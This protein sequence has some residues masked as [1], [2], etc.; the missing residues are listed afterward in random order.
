MVRAS[1]LSVDLMKVLNHLKPNLGQKVVHSL[2]AQGTEALPS[3]ASSWHPAKGQ[4]S[5]LLDLVT[6]SRLLTA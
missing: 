3:G 1:R 5:H 4:S 2:V 6:F